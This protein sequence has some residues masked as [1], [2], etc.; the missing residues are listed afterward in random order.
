[1]N[2]VEIEEAISRLAEQPFD[3]RDFPF[4]VLEAFGNK[5]TTIKKLRAGASNNSDLEG[6]APAPQHP[7]QGVPRRR[8]GRDA[9]SAQDQPCDGARE[10]EIRPRNG[11]YGVP[12][13]RPEHGRNGCLRPRR[14]PRPLRV[15]PAA[16]RHH[17]RQA[18]PRERGRHQ[19]DRTPEPALPSRCSRTT[20][21]GA[22]QAASTR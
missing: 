2:A 9:H 21:N 16:R 5:P 14:L 15:L 4:A 13:R 19:S 7:H 8:G 20:P 6:G 22:P 11:R 3:G 10:S 1:M 18:D 12:G 17:D